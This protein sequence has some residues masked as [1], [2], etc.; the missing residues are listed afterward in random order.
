[1][2]PAFSS[3]RQAAA[4]ALLLA[5][6]LASPVLVAKTGWLNRRDVYPA[7]PVKYGPFA[8]IQQQ[9]YATTNDADIVFL[10]SSHIW[11]GVNTP[12]VQ[13]KLSERL[14]REA[15][16]F[17]MAW[18]W[19]GYD[20]AYVMARDLFQHRHVRMLVIDDEDNPAYEDAPH[21]QSWRWLRPGENSDALTGLPLPVK[22]SVYGG[23]VLGTPRNLLSLVRPNLL[24]D[25]A[26]NHPDY[27]SKEFGAPNFAAQR[28]SLRVRLDFNSPRDFTPFAP[29]IAAN[30]ADAAVYSPQTRDTF[31]FTG[32]PMRPYQLFFARK[33][34]RLCQECGTRLVVLHVP[35]LK[36]QAQATI[37]ER[38]PWSEILGAPVTVVGIPGGKIFGGIPA[39]DVP[40]FFYNDTHLNQNGQ[41]RF[42]SLITPSL[43]GL[44]AAPNPAPL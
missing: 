19:P 35:V 17:T 3:S 33:L 39:P 29:P 20:A 15:Q 34:A 10:G 41:D 23:M 36:E 7:I 44:Y 6:V 21:V 14:G 4:F 18:C 31:T 40:R 30:P 24:E 13:N 8:W 9:I 16:V 12:H 43:I 42:T 28:G 2:T 26:A 1:M 5:G 25:P 38:G 11:Y 32:Q 22:L 27:W 37:P